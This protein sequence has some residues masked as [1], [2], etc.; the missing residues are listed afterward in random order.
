VQGV[1]KGT[2]EEFFSRLLANAQILH[3]ASAQ[4]A[5]DG[6]PVSAI[7]CAIGSDAATLESVVW[8]RLNIAPRAP[9]RQFFQAVA[10]V[11]SS[12]SG[13]ADLGDADVTTAIG[14]VTA[15]RERMTQAFDA[16]LALDVAERW[17]PLAHLADLPMPSGLDMDDF[18][19]QRLEGL[20]VAEFIKARRTASGQAMLQAQNFR[21]RGMLN[22][23]VQSAYDSD[24]LAMEAYLVE[25]ATAAGDTALL[26]VVARTV[27]VSDSL[28]DMSGLPAGFTEAVAAIRAAMSDGLGEADGARLHM[29]LIDLP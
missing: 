15:V 27:L 25:S 20:T 5:G 21:V 1:D 24:Y 28:A 13:L 22:E 17:E 11:A 6:D 23:A 4:F 19:A 29:A 10:T 9:Q 26:T 18:R 12:L 16:E 8:E 7:A 2:A 3:E 14:F